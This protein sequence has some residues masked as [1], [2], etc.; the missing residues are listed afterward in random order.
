M[1]VRLGLTLQLTPTTKIQ[2][3]VRNCAIREA[4]AKEKRKKDRGGRRRASHFN[5]DTGEKRPP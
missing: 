5:E 1:D 2:T 4:V 3:K